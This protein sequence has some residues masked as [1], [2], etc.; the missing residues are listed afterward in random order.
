MTA[1]VTKLDPPAN[2]QPAAATL[3]PMDISTA[4][5]ITDRHQVMIRIPITESVTVEQADRFL[6]IMV[7]RAHRQIAR[8]ELADHEQALADKKAA[9]TMQLERRE[10]ARHEYDAKTAS[11]ETEIDRLR[12]HH[13]ETLEQ[14]SA[15]HYNSGRTGDFK[16]QGALKAQLKQYVSAID[17]EIAKGLKHR[18]REQYEQLVEKPHAEIITRLEQ[19]ISAI[20]RV[21]ARHKAALTE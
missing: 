7:D 10:A 2:D 14:A 5:N 1:T 15:A 16:P 19:E 21:I 12:K 6:D 3:P 8:L 9:L 20:E 17:M 18:D 13:D 11:F 4:V